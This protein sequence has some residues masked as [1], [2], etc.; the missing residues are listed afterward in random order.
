MAILIRTKDTIPLLVDYFAARMPSVNIVS[1][2]AFRLDASV[3][4]TLLINALQY[5]AHPDDLVAK[6][7]LVKKYQQLVMGRQ[8]VDAELLRKDVNTDS[9]L[10]MG[11]VTDT[12]RLLSM[13]LYDLMQRLYQLFSL[14]SIKSQDAYLC[15]FYDYLNAYIT[16]NSSDLESFLQYWEE[17]LCSRTIQSDEV[18]G[19][20]VLTIHKSK[21]LEFEHVILPF[22]DWKLEKAYGNILWCNPTEAPFSDLPIAP[23]DYVQNQMMGTIYEQDYV[24][25]HLQNTVDNLNLLYVAFTR[26][27]KSLF[28]IGKRNAGGTRS[29]LIEECLPLVQGDEAIQGATLTDADGEPLVFE[30]G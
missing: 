29:M 14:E 13:P 18:D 9:Y 24:H 12:S 6:A 28:V 4:V 2:E 21:G 20:R 15:A 19:I 7:S 25:E 22:C 30:Y 23:I 5:L 3:S 1:D 27:C 11:Y 26:A 8:D 10:P 16:D 17:S